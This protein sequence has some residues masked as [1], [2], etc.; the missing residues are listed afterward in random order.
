MSNNYTTA[1]YKKYFFLPSWRNYSTINDNDTL[2]PWFVTGYADG[3]GCFNIKVV[4]SHSNSIGWQVQARFIIEVNIKDINLLYKI[5]AFFGDIGSVTSTNNK[6][7]Y[8]VSGLKDISDVI[9]THFINY[10]L[11]SAKK[12]DFILWQKCV[13]LMLSKKHLTQE[14]LEQI[15]SYKGAINFGESDKLKLS[16]PNI[17]PALKPVMLITDAPL[18]PFWVSGFVEAEGSFYISTNSKTNKMRPWAS[19]GLNNRDKFLLIKIN[20]F[21]GEIGSIYE[22][23]TN[24]LAEWKVF[25]LANFNLLIEHFNKYPLKGFKSYNFSIWCE[26]V[27]LFENNEL[28][29]EIMIKI[30]ELKNKLNK[31]K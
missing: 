21:F 26:I 16:F 22:T 20:N 27:K 17:I 8:Y 3:E 24:N 5:K 28:T 19:V 13:N 9:L 18:N 31:W 1:F 4:K 11:Q 25:K 7:R 14:G 10:P 29:P 23:S 12:L 30:I 6:A 15:I 2:N